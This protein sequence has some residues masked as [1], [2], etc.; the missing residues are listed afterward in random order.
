[1]AVANNP[2]LMQHEA[3]MAVQAARVALAQSD[4][5]PDLDVSLQYG[6]RPGRL[7]MITAL[8]S[9]PIPIHKSAKQ[10]AEVLG[11]R[12]DLLALDAEHRTQVN[13]LRAR[14]AKL[15]SEIERQRTQLALD[16]R[17][18]IPQGR[19][20][21]S[22]ATSNYQ[23]GKSDLLTLLDSRSTLFAYETSYYRLLSDFAESVTDLEELIGKEV[24]P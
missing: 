14:V 2:M 13:E 23:A 24:L 5:K 17:A 11:A 18:I 6:Q 4:A 16:V 15:Y 7:D 10:N 1:M 20:V 8:V 22:A 12:A 3:E 21:L 19:A 9:L